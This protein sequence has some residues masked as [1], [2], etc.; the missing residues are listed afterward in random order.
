[1]VSWP[2]AMEGAVAG[3]VARAICAPIDLVKIR[4][5]LRDTNTTTVTMIRNIYKQEGLSAFWRGNLSGMALYATYGAIQFSI[6][7]QLKQ[8]GVGL[9]GGMA[10]MMATLVTY[11]LDLL[12]TRMSLQSGWPSNL[13]LLR[14]VWQFDGTLYRGLLPTLAQVAPY[15]AI[16]FWTFDI[17]QAHANDAIAGLAAGLVGKTAVLPLDNLRKRLQSQTT[18]AQRQAYAQ[19]IPLHTST[20]LWHCIREM[21]HMG[22]IPAFYRGWVLA[23]SKSAP[24][25]AITM[26]VYHTLR[27]MHGK[28]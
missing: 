18:L 21:Y 7:E 16:T 25:A 19:A 20:N 1:M 11:P 13:K 28:E 17:C 8:H 24:T 15:M 22:G 3:V 5:Q 14:D 10:A 23:V 9:A 12:R 6:Y 2:P 27:R 26:V 4:W